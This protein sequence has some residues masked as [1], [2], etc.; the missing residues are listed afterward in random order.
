MFV[1]IA[2]VLALIVAAAGFSVFGGTDSAGGCTLNSTRPCYDKNKSG[3]ISVLKKGGEKAFSA[4]LQNSAPNEQ[5]TGSIISSVCAD[6]QYSYSYC[7]EGKSHVYLRKFAGIC[8]QTPPEPGP[9][10][11]PLPEPLPGPAPTT[12]PTSTGPIAFR[13]VSPNGGE[14]L[15][16]G[17]SFPVRWE[18]GDPS[19]PLDIHIDRLDGPL[20]KSLGWNFS[21][22]GYEDWAVDLAP[23]QYRVSMGC[24]RD[25]INAISH[26]WDGSDTAFS[27]VDGSPWGRIA[28][29]LTN[30]PPVILFP[31]G[32][33][34]WTAGSKHTIYWSGGDDN[35]LMNLALIEYPYTHSIIVD[36]T[37]NDGVYEWTIPN[38]VAPG[39]YTI[40]L[41]CQNCVDSGAPLGYLYGAYTYSKEFTITAP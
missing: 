29:F 39:I 11:E 32:G 2:S 27:V 15:A 1:K 12:T 24:P 37:M 36:G 5:G 34:S 20:G 9:L 8:P 18:G 6:E 14:S 31:K 41:S 13:V 10:P 26:T 4:C 38:S 28:R 23:G 3:S 35:S 25:C 17:S 21:N 40:Y 19:W 16:F 30:R 33:E 7:Y 22:D